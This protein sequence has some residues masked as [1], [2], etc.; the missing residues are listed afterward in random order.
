MVPT[1]AQVPEGNEAPLGAKW[2]AH[3]ARRTVTRPRPG[4]VRAE[5]TFSGAAKDA[6]D[7]G[8]N[9]GIN[10]ANKIID[11]AMLAEIKQQLEQKQDRA[12]KLF[13]LYVN[14]GLA[15]WALYEYFWVA[16]FPQGDFVRCQLVY[17]VAAPLYKPS[18]SRCG[19]A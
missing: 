4:E 3:E 13:F 11:E 5:V 14:I 18:R 19:R 7:E 6:V 12:M 15:Y 16:P 8:A 17:V 9:K 2:I 1:A 10:A